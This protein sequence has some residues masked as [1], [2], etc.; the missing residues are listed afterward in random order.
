MAKE[1]L[2][3]SATVESMQATPGLKW[4]VGPPDVIPMFIAS[5]DFPIAPEIK[6]ALIEAVEAED[7]Y[8][9]LDIR[10]R[11]AMA[12][13]ITRV[14][15]VD[16]TS[17]D[18]MITQGVDPGIWLA[19][20]HACGQGDEVVITNPSYG[21]FFRVTNSA[22]ARAV[23]WDLDYEG[24][25]AFDVEMLKE[26]VTDRT[27][28]IFVC[29]PH[30]P[31]GR[32]LTD[33]ELKGIADVAVDNEI[34]VMSDELWEDITFDGRRHVTIASLNPEIERLTITSWGFSKTFGVAGLQLGYLCA[35]DREMLGDL[36]RHASAIQRGSSTL[37]K[38]VAPMMLD[39]TLDWWRRGMMEHLHRIRAICE[40]RMERIPG[41]TFPRLEGTYVPF[42]RFDY[43]M[44]SQE[45]R[46]YL[47]EEARIGL[48]VGTGYGSRGEGHLRIC[49]ATSEAILNE[50]LDRMETALSKL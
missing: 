26:L 12:D 20:R 37:A 7:L 41:V 49:I 33:E 42:P 36:K 24:G 15:G 1:D 43:G 39:D 10:A 14:N 2:F 29:N 34:V 5:P 18:V 38:A 4:H 13:K 9:N 46:D 40:E 25:Y 45:L 22:G 23:Y 3:N 17:D 19:V 11:E 28:L 16:A 50:A 6:R 32:V 48:S 21:P 35:T 30:N 31:C 44:T 8:Y 27:R 47:Y